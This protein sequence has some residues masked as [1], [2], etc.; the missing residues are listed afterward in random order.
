MRDELGAWGRSGTARA[1]PRKEVGPISALHCLSS[2]APAIF[3][4][5]L[6]AQSTI[7]L[8]VPDYYYSVL[9]SSN[10]GRCH[11]GVRLFL[12]DWTMHISIREVLILVWSSC[13]HLPGP[14]A[15]RHQSLAPQGPVMAYSMPWGTDIPSHWHRPLYTAHHCDAQTCRAVL[16]AQPDQRT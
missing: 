16:I 14:G 4:Q 6:C 10:Y 1:S 13:G 11:V 7:I 15:P 9:R 2:N 3:I 12:S 5:P 8:H